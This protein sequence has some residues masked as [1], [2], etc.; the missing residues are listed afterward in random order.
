MTK[1]VVKFFNVDRGFGFAKPDDG[2]AD[3]FL[4]ASAVEGHEI[5]Q[6]GDIV[7]FE[8]GIGLSSGKTR[9]NN[10]RLVERGA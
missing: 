4:H 6:E 2:G 10:I 9:A 5:L 8:I 3:I 1:G 7:E